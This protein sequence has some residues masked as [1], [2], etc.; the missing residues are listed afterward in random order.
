MARARGGHCV[1]VGEKSLPVQPA[2]IAPGKQPGGKL[3]L[4]AGSPDTGFFTHVAEGFTAISIGQRARIIT[5]RSE[6]EAQL[7]IREDADDDGLFNARRRTREQLRQ[8]VELKAGQ[9]GQFVLVSALK[10]DIANQFLKQVGDRFHRSPACLNEKY[11]S[12]SPIRCPTI[13]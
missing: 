3:A 6:L 11:G 2:P 9:R 1:H 4:I 13:T 12:R 8:G 7:T 5:E 10:M